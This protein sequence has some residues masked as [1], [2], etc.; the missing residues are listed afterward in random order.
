MSDEPVDVPPMRTGTGGV[1]C[2]K[3]AI[4]FAQRGTE[5]GIADF[6]PFVDQR[7]AQLV[8]VRHC[9][10]HLATMLVVVSKQ[11]I[12][13]HRSEAFRQI[14]DVRIKYALFLSL[15]LLR[16]IDGG[17]LFRWHIIRPLKPC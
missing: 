10:S 15:E 14:G 4:G 3:R 5:L 1:E 17:D 11:A 8:I 6:Q 7:F 2:H 16:G 9:G 13:R 12:Q